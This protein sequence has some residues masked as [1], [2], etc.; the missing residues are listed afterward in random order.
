MVDRR[1]LIAGIMMA[2]GMG[3]A[4]GRSATSPI[5]IAAVDGVVA[6]EDITV[7]SASRHIVEVDA[8]SAATTG[9]PTSV[10]LL[11]R[12]LF[13]GRWTL[14]GDATVVQTPSGRSRWTIRDVAFD[15]PDLGLGYELYAASV[16]RHALGTPGALIDYDTVR[17][18][19]VAIS[20]PVRVRFST[21]VPRVDSP[22]GCFVEL[23]DVVDVDGHRRSRG[24]DA[25]GP[26]GVGANA[27]LGAEAVVPAG[28]GA[29][30]IV[31]PI[32]GNEV[33]WI[34]PTNGTY[35][36]RRLTAT[37]QLGR[38][39]LDA[40]KQFKVQGVISRR[41]IAGGFYPP[42][43]WAALDRDFCARSAEMI[44]RREIEPMDLVVE[45]V[46]DERATRQTIPVRSLPFQVEGTVVDKSPR[47]A[48]VP[49]ETVW[50]LSR[51]VDRDDRWI[52]QNLAMVSLNH[53]D[54]RA[55]GIRLVPGTYRLIAVASLRPLTRGAAI[56]DA[57]W[58]ARIRARS[59]R[60]LS[61]A[62]TIEI[63]SSSVTR[64]DR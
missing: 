49:G 34:T 3:A 22:S 18:A 44:V 10:T 15:A 25:G 36:D 48:L 64:S 52:V 11:V 38:P 35:A 47:T 41:P 40:G 57:D 4:P 19:S 9:A 39:E 61:R 28:G 5:G 8:A 13:D 30:L 53:F 37:L 17:R 55:P 21:A 50:I 6:T 51:H 33:R 54:W 58:Y 7:P 59:M 42:D 29:Y 24:G 56:S 16:D 43:A 63:N 26:I 23:T 2:V 1:L 20:K 14:L 31:T 46:E 27:E 45:A 32:D 62:V 60:R 12:R